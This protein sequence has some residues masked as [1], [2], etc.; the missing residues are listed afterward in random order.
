MIRLL[1][2]MSPACCCLRGVG[3]SYV[4]GAFIVNLRVRNGVA[5]CSRGGGRGKRHGTDFKI[6]DDDKTIPVEKT[7][8]KSSKMIMS[9]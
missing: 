7:D 9:R 8:S 2:V 3:A 4:L 1:L 5:E 6:R